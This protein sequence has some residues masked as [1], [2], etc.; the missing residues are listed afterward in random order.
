MKIVIL[1]LVGIILTSLCFLYKEMEI[2]QLIMGGII[3]MV[4]LL[5][6]ISEKINEIKNK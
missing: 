4:L 2:R 5:L 6:Y 1:I 3:L